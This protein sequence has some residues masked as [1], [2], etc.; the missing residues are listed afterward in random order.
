MAHT[1]IN[2]PTPRSRAGGGVR[3]IGTLVLA[4]LVIAIILLATKVVTFEQLGWF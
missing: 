3:L 2:D 1:P 4:F